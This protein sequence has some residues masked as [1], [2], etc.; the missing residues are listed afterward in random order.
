[1][2]MGSFKPPPLAHAAANRS[3][4]AASLLKQP[5]LVRAAAARSV[6]PPPLGRCNGEATRTRTKPFPSKHSFI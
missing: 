1:M 3:Y 2:S 5:P 6:R 4:T